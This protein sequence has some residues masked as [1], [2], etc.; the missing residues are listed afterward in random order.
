[1]SFVD[2]RRHGGGHHHHQ[3][4]TSGGSNYRP[5]FTTRHLAALNF[6]L[7][8]PMQREVELR[9]AGLKFSARVHFEK[10]EE[11]DNQETNIR[12]S[13][14][15]EDGESAATSATLPENIGSYMRAKGSHAPVDAA[16]IKLK[17]PIVHAV[18]HSTQFRYCFNHLSEQS[19]ISRSWEEGV[20]NA[21]SGP[22]SSV[23]PV[24][25]KI[26]LLSNRLFMCRARNYPNAVLSIVRY[27][28]GE[29]K[30]KLEKLKADDTKGLEVFRLPE[31][32]WRG[33]SYSSLF[34]PL[35]EQLQL[36]NSAVAFGANAHTDTYSGAVGTFERGNFQASSVSNDAGVAESTLFS[37][38][39]AASTTTAS[40]PIGAAV[41]SNLAQDLGLVSASQQINRTAASTHG[42]MSNASL[43]H[44]DNPEG[45]ASCQLLE[46]GY[47][48]DPNSVDDPGLLYGSHRY[49]SQRRAPT[50]PII[51]S[52]ILFV[53]KQELKESLNEQFRERHPHLPPSLTL[54]KIRNLKKQALLASFSIGIEVSTMALSVLNFERLCLKS[55]VT[56]FNRR[57]TMALSMLLAFKFNEN[58]TEEYHKKLQALLQFFDREWNLPKRQ[59]FDAEFGAF[60]LLGFSMHLPYKHIYLSFTRLL[61]LIS[62][63]SKQYLGERMNEVYVN[64]IL[65]ME[66]RTADIRKD[67]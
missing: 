9:E 61:K 5:K 4:V 47:A 62:Q 25:S 46:L 13:M 36:T 63:T 23:A 21:S 31:R 38:A 8:V 7:A 32:D 40:A 55:I 15:E 56:K 27:D 10:S 16:G 58:I 66:R 11:S 43:S 53:K 20:L 37:T 52:V 26:G 24:S 60:V 49:V 42:Y 30:A 29:E 64:D 34:R 17:G 14:Q 67:T 54:S 59:I 51:S 65:C 3:Y 45:L 19:A 44:M 2:T 18:H 33:C 28:A 39:T 35:L 22:N 50:G 41:Q 6:L 1:M 57:L 48:Y 12:S